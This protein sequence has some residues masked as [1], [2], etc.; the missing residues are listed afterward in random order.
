MIKN[1]Y[2]SGIMNIYYNLCLV[3]KKYDKTIHYFFFGSK[4]LHYFFLSLYVSIFFLKKQN[5]FVFKYDTTLF[6]Y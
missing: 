5:I 6:N 2:D 3:P 4:T 1:R